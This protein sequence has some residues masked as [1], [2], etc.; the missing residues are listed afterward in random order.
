MTRAAK[1]TRSD[2]NRTLIAGIQ[3][4]LASAPTII[5]DG[6]PFTPTTLTKALQAEIDAFDA[7]AAAGG[8]FHKAVAAQKVAETEVEPV[9]RAFKKFVLNQFHGQA[10]ALADFGITVKARKVPTAEE[11]AAA[12]AKRKAT[13]AAGGKAAKAKATATTAAPQG[14]TAAPATP[15]KPA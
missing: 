1:P 2:R 11:K 7:T 13:R 8:V 9:V 10:D 14:T 15:S 3:K 12:A 6:T 4:R 5:L